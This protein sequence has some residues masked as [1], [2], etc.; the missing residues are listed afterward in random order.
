MTSLSILPEA[1]EEFAVS[2]LYYE[3]QQR[4]L[5]KAF[6]TEVEN[7]FERILQHPKAA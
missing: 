5:G 3:S 6:V 2:A 1:S 7:S 4:G